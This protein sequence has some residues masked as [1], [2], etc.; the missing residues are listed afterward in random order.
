[1]NRRRPSPS[2]RPKPSSPPK[3]KTPKRTPKRKTPKPKSSRLKAPSGPEICVQLPDESNC[4]KPYCNVFN[5]KSGFNLVDYTS[6]IKPLIP[7]EANN[8][9]YCEMDGSKVYCGCRK[10]KAID[11]KCSDGYEMYSVDE[12]ACGSDIRTGRR[13]PAMKVTNNYCREKNLNSKLQTPRLK[14]PDESEICVQLPEES[15]CKKPYCNVFNCNNGFNLVDY[16][17]YI[18]PLVPCEENKQLYCEMNGTKVYCNCQN[19][20]AIDKKCPDGYE[21][22]TKRGDCNRIRSNQVCPAMLVTHELCRKSQ[23][24]SINK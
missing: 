13:C 23:F 24:N 4:E 18:K 2:F 5:C 15:N 10:I 7:C 21:F 14:A 8:Q 22:Y 20:R 16:T 1:M 11:K 9:L 19:I 3:R 17:N 12:R 6:Y